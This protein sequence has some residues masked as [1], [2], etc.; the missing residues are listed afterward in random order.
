MPSPREVDLTAE[1]QLRY[2]RQ[3]RVTEFGVE[4]QLRLKKSRTVIVGAGGLGCPVAMYLAGAGVGS[5]TIVDHDAIDISNI[6]RQVAYKTEDV[7]KSKATVLVDT[8]DGINPDLHYEAKKAYLSIENAFELLEGY[9]LVIDGS[10]NFSAKFLIADTC[11]AL[12]IPLIHGS[13]HQH[14]AQIALLTFGDGPCFRC[15][16][17]EPPKSGALAS[18]DQ[19]GVLGVV[20]GTAGMLMAVEAVKYLGGMDTVC[21]NTMLKY[22]SAKQILQQI[23]ISRD[24]DCPL[25]SNSPAV[26]TAPTAT[27]ACQTALVNNFNSAIDNE[28][29][30]LERA[31]ALIDEG[32]FLLDVREPIEYEISHL[33]DSVLIPLSRLYQEGAAQLPKGKPIVVYCQHG[34]RSLAAVGLLRAA[35]YKES[36]S[37]AGGIASWES[38]ELNC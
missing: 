27:I 12:Q 11:Y 21:R 25:C 13:V 34:V 10:D 6:H 19:A 15:L 26:R 24:D 3:L 20:A 36:Y 22:D 18:C 7:K 30:S 17:S 38:V 37:I 16:Y 14:S 2:S 8:I 33:A 1:E 5:I 4:G 23:S 32:A 35:G 9:D 28:I 31:K 29:I